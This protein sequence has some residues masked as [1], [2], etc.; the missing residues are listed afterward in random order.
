MVDLPGD[1]V[2]YRVDVRTSDLS[3]TA[4]VASLKPSAAQTMGPLIN[5]FHFLIVRPPSVAGVRGSATVEATRLRDNK[6]VPVEFAFETVEGPGG[7]L[8][9]IRI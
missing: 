4:Q 2:G 8:G 3:W 9:C 5:S 6:I 1:S 7:S